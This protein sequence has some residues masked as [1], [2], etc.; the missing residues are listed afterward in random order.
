MKTSHPPLVELDREEL[1]AIIERS[2]LS[3]EERAQ[4]RA[5]VEAYALVSHHID[6]NRMT[7]ARL[8]KMLFGARTE[9]TSTLQTASGSQ[10]SSAHGGPAAGT[11]AA[12]ADKPKRKGH[13]RNGA[14]RYRGAERVFVPH[15]S[16]RPGDPCPECHDG[17]LYELRA[18]AVHV[19]VR[20]QA[21]IAATV[22][23]HERLRCNPCGAV[24]EAS[25]PPGVGEEKYDE[26]VP[27]MLI[28]LRFG[29]GAPHTRLDRLQ[30]SVG[31]PLPASTQ[32]EIISRAVNV[33]LEVACAELIRE[34]AQGELVHNDDTPAKILARM[35]ERRRRRAAAEGSTDQPKPDVEPGPPSSKRVGTFT[36]SIVSVSGGRRIALFFTGAQHAGENLKDLL[37]KRS[38][39]LPAPIQ[40]CDALTANLPKEL[41]TIVAHCLA[42]GRRQF[43]EVYDQFPAQCLH[44]LD[45][46]RE[47]YHND[48][49]ARERGMSASERLAWH[50]AQSGPVMDK[51][52]R[53]LEAELAEKRVEPNSS[54]GEAISYMLNHWHRLTQ[55]LR[56]A[57][58]PLDNNICERALKKAI[59]HRRNSLFYK[60][61]NGAH[62]GDVC[63]SLIHT[64]ELC[65]AN[66]FDYLVT[67][68]RR[69]DEVRAAPSEWMPWNYADT[70][71]R[72]EA[73]AA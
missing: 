2:S 66:A 60:T 61:E 41:K 67:L 63:M 25:A 39:E 14:A 51:L 58:A 43:V 10:P 59:L 24:I 20:G 1:L 72:L 42:H 11:G 65:G 71:A 45:A 64:A 15:A 22:Y 3:P 16:L 40:M 56:V 69:A 29:N 46:L 26:T 13:G 28:V 50:Q 53:W 47:V 68:L 5:V 37:A 44:V 73:I 32:W 49:I 33:A 55:F 36:T 19:R 4:L 52:Q 30:S 35:A 6:G 70:R 9:K 34:A 54:L 23:E 57:G 38:C 48:E 8:R 21:P 12:A 18:P 27:A 62:V 7:V 17:R 31:V